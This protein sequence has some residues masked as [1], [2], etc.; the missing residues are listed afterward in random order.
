MLGG[1][2]DYQE[3]KS[4]PVSC[5]EL[6]FGLRLWLGSR[7]SRRRHEQYLN[8]RTAVVLV[9]VFDNNHTCAGGCHVEGEVLGMETREFCPGATYNAANEFYYLSEPW[10]LRCVQEASFH[11][12]YMLRSKVCR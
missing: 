1:D 10:K 3:M 2:T 7:C 8:R 6:C 5:S 12:D 11:R 9:E 4:L